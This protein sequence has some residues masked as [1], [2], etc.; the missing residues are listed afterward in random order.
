MH[1]LSV[2]ARLIGLASRVAASFLR[3][4]IAEDLLDAVLVH[5]RLVELELELGNAPQLQALADLAAEKAG[6]ALERLRGLAARS[7]VAQRRVVDARHLQVRRDLH[8]RQRD[9]PDA[10]VVHR[11]AG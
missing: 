10:G 7:L 2:A 8:P 6:R 1:S 3:V 5:H 4:Q 9:E 11:A